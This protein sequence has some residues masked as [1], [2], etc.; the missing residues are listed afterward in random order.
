M[1]YVVYIE[2]SWDMDFGSE[3][4]AAVLETDGDALDALAQY[5]LDGGHQV[6]GAVPVQPGA[7]VLVLDEGDDLRTGKGLVPVTVEDL[8]RFE[9]AFVHCRLPSVPTFSD[10]T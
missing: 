2:H 5:R 6:I 9:E 4:C 7:K 8:P 3:P 10:R 1:L